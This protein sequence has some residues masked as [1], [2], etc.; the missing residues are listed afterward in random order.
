ML[1]P[2][3]TSANTVFEPFAR[4][5]QQRRQPA[6]AR[7]RGR[8]SRAARARCHPVV[9]ARTRASRRPGLARGRGLRRQLALN[10]GMRAFRS[11]LSAPSSRFPALM[12]TT[13]ATAATSRRGRSAPHGIGATA[14]PLRTS[15]ASDHCGSRTFTSAPRSSSTVMASILPDAAAVQ[16]RRSCRRQ[17]AHVCVRIASRRTMAPWPSFAA[18]WSGV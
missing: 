17:A 12:S 15:T 18:M 2:P 11:R 9:T 4:G 8:R 7:R 16:R 1:A 10:R 13:L 6:F 5:Q 14:W 3:S